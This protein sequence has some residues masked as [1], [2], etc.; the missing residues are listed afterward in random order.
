MFLIVTPYK[1]N[2]DTSS[3]GSVVVDISWHSSP[4][5]QKSLNKTSTQC[6]PNSSYVTS[7][8]LNIDLNLALEIGI[9]IFFTYL[10]A[11]CPGF[12]MSIYKPPKY[13]SNSN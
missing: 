4:C 13:L 8:L 1:I 7:S 11:L 2:K 10:A 3:V 6:S 9:M 12:K 5:S